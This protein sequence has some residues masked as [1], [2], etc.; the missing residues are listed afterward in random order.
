MISKW[1]VGTLNAL[2]TRPQSLTFGKII[3]NSWNQTDFYIVK[4]VLLE[5][6]NLVANVKAVRPERMKMKLVQRQLLRI[7]ETQCANRAHRITIPMVVQNAIHR[8]VVL[9]TKN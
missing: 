1:C 6:K 5:R 9:M 7:T 8:P 4:N 3:L 2:G